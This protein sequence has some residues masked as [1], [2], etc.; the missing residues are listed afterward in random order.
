VIAG[1]NLERDS[2]AFDRAPNRVVLLGRPV[3]GIVAW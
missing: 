3:I 1:A 2:Q